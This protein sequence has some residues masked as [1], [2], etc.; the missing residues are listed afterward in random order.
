M[1][2]RLFASVTVLA[3]A[4]LS[5]V[6]A[7]PATGAQPLN[8]VALGD[9][10]SAASGVLPI[11]SG[12]PLLC[13]R[14]ARNY[15]HVLA[16]RTG[17]T[18]V[19]VTCGAAETSHF[20]AAQYPGVPAQVEALG[21]DTDLVTMTIGGNDSGVFIGAILACGSA[22]IVTLGHGNPC[23]TIY[24]S[25][26]EDTVRNTTYPAL[27]EALTAVVDRAPN[28]EVAILGY[29]WIVP[30]SGGCFTRMP[31]AT[32]DVPYVRS[33]QATLNDAV[34]RAAA[35]TG[36]TYVDLSAASNGHD[37]CQP[38]GVRWIEPVLH[39]TNPVV[40]H[41]NALGESNMAATTS[42]ALGLG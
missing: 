25:R 11:A 29:P 37:A 8:Y 5:L 10:Y 30:E 16:E 4:A 2:R 28:A 22:G 23:Q 42:Q 3:A 33:L 15:P 1:S 13:L 36:A 20:T 40:V 6:T 14:S 19:D 9:S 17:A 26:F 24:G 32:G 7:A 27:V 12:S 41:P 38:Q 35:A 31:I 34:R 18:L 39:T 21:E